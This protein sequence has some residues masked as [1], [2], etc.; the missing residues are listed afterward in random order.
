M[1]PTLPTVALL[2]LAR[3][4][5]VSNILGRKRFG[6]IALAAMSL[7]EVSVMTSCATSLDFSYR[8]NVRKVQSALNEIEPPLPTWQLFD[9][10][11]G[12]VSGPCTNWG[13]CPTAYR[14]WV[15]LP[16]VHRAKL[17]ALFES[18]GW[19][20]LTVKEVEPD[21]IPLPGSTGDAGGEI[22][23]FAFERE[24]LYA[25]LVVRGTSPPYVELNVGLSKYDK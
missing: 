24:D 8:S 12:T 18:V 17:V 9:D 5:S 23:R 3:M 25:S 11:V 4:S 13:G 1:P 14:I 2:C 22:C 20:V 6:L 19:T 21:C 15:A 7:L 16:S 10:G